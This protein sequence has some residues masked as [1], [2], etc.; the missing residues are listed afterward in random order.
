MYL[1]LLPTSIAALVHLS[2]VVSG[3]HGQADVAAG[4][5][6][7]LEVL[8]HAHVQGGLRGTAAAG[9]GW[10]AVGL[11]VYIWDRIKAVVSKCIYLRQQRV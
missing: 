11:R 9:L 2:I 4:V 5:A 8:V 3:W 1:L 7:A 10:R 6:A